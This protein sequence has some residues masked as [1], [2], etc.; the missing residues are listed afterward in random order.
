MVGKEKQCSLWN[1]YYKTIKRSCEV[2]VRVERQKN[3]FTPAE[4]L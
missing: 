4:S 1:Y 2:G 3:S